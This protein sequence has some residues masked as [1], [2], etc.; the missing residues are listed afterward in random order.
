MSLRLQTAQ[1]SG[2]TL[3]IW[4]ARAIELDCVIKNGWPSLAR[5]F[6]PESP[7]H[8]HDSKAW[9][10]YTYFQPDQNWAQLGPLL[11]G[12]FQI[13]FQPLND[14]EWEA[15]CFKYGA[16]ARGSNQLIAASRCIVQAVYGNSVL[17][18]T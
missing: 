6:D 10:N 7:A 17:A 14:S 15:K 1:L 4:V 8:I 16:V 5:D 18:D 9:K 3:A 12:E 13:G 11:N 2:Q